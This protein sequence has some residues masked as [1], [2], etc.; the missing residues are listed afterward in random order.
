MRGKYNITVPSNMLLVQLKMRSDIPTRNNAG[1]VDNNPN[2]RKIDKCKMYSPGA[3]AQ[4]VP[5]P[6]TAIN[7]II[8]ASCFM[9]RSLARQPHPH[10]RTLQLPHGIAIN[11]AIVST[12]S[13]RFCSRR[14][15]LAAC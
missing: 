1:N 8:N 13:H 7:P 4:K 6:R 2:S 9:H 5:K 11:A 12:P 10:S 3:A 14:F 15:S